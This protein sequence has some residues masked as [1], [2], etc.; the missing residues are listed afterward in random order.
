MICVS[1]FQKNLL[2]VF[3]KIVHIYDTERKLNKKDPSKN[4]RGRDLNIELW[5][6]QFVIFTK[7]IFSVL[8]GVA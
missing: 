7:N 1:I 6:F 5:R 2:I 8:F 4:C 3:I